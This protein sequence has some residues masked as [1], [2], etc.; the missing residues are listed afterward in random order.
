MIST[1]KVEKKRRIFPDCSDG[2]K[3][4]ADIS[5]LGILIPTTDK[6]V[7]A[8]T[9]PSDGAIRCVCVEVSFVFLP[10]SFSLTF[11]CLWEIL[12]AGTS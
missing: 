7:R 5:L 3:E 4:T 10:W 8:H 1:V 12:V 6:S 2:T 11:I 9:P